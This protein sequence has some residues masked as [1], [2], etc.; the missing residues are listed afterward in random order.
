MHRPLLP[1]TGHATLPAPGETV[2]LQ[3]ELRSPTGRV[4]EI[5]ERLTVVACDGARVELDFAASEGVGS[6]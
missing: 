6:C 4:L 2:V 5:G 1:T 3:T